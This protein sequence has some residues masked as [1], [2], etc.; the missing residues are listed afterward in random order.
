MNSKIDSIL[1]C[2]GIQ[3]L[4]NEQETIKEEKTVAW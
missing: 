3:K 1:S 4:K 2:K